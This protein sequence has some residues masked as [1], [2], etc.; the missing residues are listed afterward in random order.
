MQQHPIWGILEH[1]G[2][3]LKWLARRIERSEDLV[4]F[5]KTGRRNA[6]NEFRQRCSGALDLPESALF[7]DG[8]ASPSERT[9]EEPAPNDGSD[10]DG[11]TTAVPLASVAT[12]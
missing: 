8:G 7:H 3:S 2:R 6:T 10:S 12:P 1:Q 11:D 5:V 9:S 4:L